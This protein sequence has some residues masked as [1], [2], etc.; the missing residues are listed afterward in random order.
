M[1]G[2][3]DRAASWLS[4]RTFR[5]QTGPA[6]AE[7]DDPARREKFPAIPAAADED[8]AGGN[9]K[10]GIPTSSPD[11]QRS[12]DRRASSEARDPRSVVRVVP[13]SYRS[14]R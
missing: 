1:G 3:R 14:R 9:E 5:S 7:R 12:D 13:R 11:E 4:F 2:M 6:D 8:F 10:D